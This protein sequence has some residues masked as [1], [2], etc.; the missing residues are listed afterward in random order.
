[1]PLGLSFFWTWRYSRWAEKKEQAKCQ[2]CQDNS[3]QK[4]LCGKQ[5]RSSCCQQESQLIPWDRQLVMLRSEPQIRRPGVVYKSP[6]LAPDRHCM[7]C[8]LSMWQELQDSRTRV[9]LYGNRHGQMVCLAISPFP[10]L[11][12]KGLGWLL[13]TLQCKALLLE[14]NIH[15]SKNMEK[16]SWCLPRAF[17]LMDRFP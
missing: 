16:L 1:M 7:C 5:K 4:Q 17:T 11:Q 12:T 8:Y 3:Q 2:D 15:N 13:A 9:C 6:Q 10:Q 14:R